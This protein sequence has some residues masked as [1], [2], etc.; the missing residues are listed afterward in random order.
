MAVVRLRKIDGGAGG[1]CVIVLDSTRVRREVLTVIDVTST[2]LVDRSGIERFRA[3]GFLLL[4]RAFDPGPLEDELNTAL[5]DGLR[6]DAAVN[7]GSGGIGFQ[8]VVMMCELTLV[9][10]S[11][12]D[13]LAPVASQLLER[14]SVP[15]RAK[16]IRYT[17]STDWHRDS[18][19]PVPGMSFV[20]YLESLDAATGALRVRPRSHTDMRNTA[21]DG[22]VLETEPG[23]LIAFDDHLMH[24]SFGGTIRRQWRI[25]FSAD[26]AGTHEESL[27]RAEY[28]RI[29]DGSR[30]LGDDVERYPSFGQYWRSLDR[31]WTTRLADLG[32]YELADR[33]HATRLRSRAPR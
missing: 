32:V 11:L 33:Y 30:D 13:R 22:L 14:D 4:Q 18:D 2:P 5:R 20:A 19:V 12:L 29:L 25:D 26:P 10:L 27:T 15:G 17:G 8:G 23:D 6:S 1:C 7:L 16:G 31:P 3:E 24:A 21:R 9:S 28:A